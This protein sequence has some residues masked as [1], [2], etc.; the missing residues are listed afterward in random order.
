MNIVGGI[1]AGGRSRRMEGMD[2]PFA[3]LAG[4]PLIAHVISRLMPQSGEVMI[5]ANG[6]AERFGPFG[7]DVIADRIGGFK[8][9]LAGLHAL[10][11]AAHKRGASHLLTAPADTPFLP[12]DLLARLL[13]AGSDPR[14]ARIAKSNGRPQPLAG[15]WPVDLMPGLEAHLTGTEDLSMIAYLRQIENCEAAFEVRDG[16]DPFFNIN[17]PMDLEKAEHLMAVADRSGM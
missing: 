14:V 2:K 10:M 7:L 8:G 6:E 13:A 16:L 17:T 9:P 4:K 1:L 5:N 3:K 12:H 11:A 15:L